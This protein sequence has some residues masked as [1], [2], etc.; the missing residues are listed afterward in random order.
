MKIKGVTLILMEPYYPKGIGE[1][2]AKRTNA[3]LLVLPT[4]VD[5]VPEVKDYFDLF[6]YDVKQLMAVEQKTNK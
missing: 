2:V 5:G 1:D 3:T 4:E 6:D